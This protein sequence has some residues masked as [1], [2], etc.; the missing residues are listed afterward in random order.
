MGVDVVGDDVVGDD[1]GVTR[2]SLARGAAA[3]AITVATAALLVATGPR[4][5][6]VWDEGYTQYRSD[7]RKSQPPVT[8][9]LLRTEATRRP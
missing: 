9:G 4:L 5:A 6:I 8:L 2:A 7:R 3:L 1:R